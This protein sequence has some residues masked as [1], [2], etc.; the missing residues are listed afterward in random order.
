MTCDALW[1]RMVRENMLPSIFVA[2]QWQMFTQTLNLK[3][4]Y[5]SLPEMRTLMRRSAIEKSW[6][7]KDVQVL[8]QKLSSF[9][10]SGV[11]IF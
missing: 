9:E 5:S 6:Y 8:I 4:V 3:V 1:T 7:G 2:T 11:R 10:K